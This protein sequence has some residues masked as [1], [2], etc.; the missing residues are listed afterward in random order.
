MENL[1]LHSIFKHMK[2][3]CYNPKHNSYK[4]YGGCG[5][6]V[7]DKW[8]TPH[9]QKG[10]RA[11]RDWALSHGYTDKLTIDRLDVNKGYSPENCRWVTMKVQNNNTRSNRRI[12]YKGKTQTLSQWCE[13]LGKNYFM[14]HARLDK[15]HWSIEKAFEK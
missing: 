6:R 13:E 4:Y 5:I 7:C 10:W 12:T 9:S 2:D 14:V 15:L 1:R 11:F 3:R 8:N